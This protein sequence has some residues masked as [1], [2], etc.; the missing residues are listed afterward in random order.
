MGFEDGVYV[1]IYLFIRTWVWNG[2]P[3]FTDTPET[4]QLTYCDCGLDV[5]LKLSNHPVPPTHEAKAGP[6]PAQ[7]ARQTTLL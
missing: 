4:S 5:V 3:G 1:F 7:L 6:P 2:A